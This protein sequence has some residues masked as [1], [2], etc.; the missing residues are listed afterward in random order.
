MS[1]YLYGA[2]VQGIQEFIFKTN[3]LKDIVGASEMVEIIS[4]DF[5]SKYE[6]YCDV[7]QKAAGNIKI[8]FNT[9]KDV[10]EIVKHLPK[11]VMQY[12]YGI[13]LSQAVVT[14]NGTLTKDDLDSL[15]EKLKSARN[16]PT[17]PLD[18][19]IN[20]MKLS[21]TTGRATCSYDRSKK[22]FIDYATE[23]K[24]ATK[25][26]RLEK[27]IDPEAKKH[28]AQELSEISNKKNKVAVIH[29]DGN[30]LGKLLQNLAKKLETNSLDIKE[31]FTKF[32]KAIDNATKKAA[33]EAYDNMGSP[34][35]FRP[36]VLGG[37]DLSVICSADIAI[38]FT[39]H[40]LKLFEKY[41]KEELKELVNGYNLNEFKNGLTACAG[42]TFANE[43]YPFHY[44]INLA[45]ELCSY[46]KTQSKKINDTLAPSS[47]MFYN[48]QS[49]FFVSYRDFVQKELEVTETIS[50]EF[51]PYYVDKEYGATIEDLSNF[52]KCLSFENSP[53]S[54]LREWLSE[55][56]EDTTYAESLLARIDQVTDSTAK[57]A[58]N[59][60]L[61][62]LHKDL[63]LS[64]LFVKKEGKEISPVHDGVKLASILGEIQ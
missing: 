16:R 13:T 5:S 31:V 12:A 10:Q 6:N 46:A 25:P 43:K 40:F 48:V 1:K 22:E 37:D 23:K 15:E 2:S 49:S 7:I 64:K 20:I 47:L 45:E 38:D 35:D 34:E 51:G 21:P 8:L 33:K 53:K 59:N 52:A 63:S 58:T 18:S 19:N 42:I 44:S 61:K 54:R 50:F 60:V 32:S 55:I 9:E 28:F 24:R 62:R 27:K 39:N 36:I 4:Q 3:R 57:I 14:V 30:G 56:R 17:L 11:E 29:A 41:T 26:H